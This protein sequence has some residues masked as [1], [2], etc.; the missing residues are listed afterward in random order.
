MASVTQILDHQ[1]EAANRLPERHKDKVKLPGLIR[2]LAVPASGGD[3]EVKTEEM[4][5]QLLVDRSITTAVGA[6]LDVIGRI[7]GL[8]RAEI[9]SSL[10]DADYRRYVRAKI[11]EQRS[12][13]IAFD[14][15]RVMRQI[16]IEETADVVLEYFFPAG[17]RIRIDGIAVTTDISAIAADFLRGSAAAGVRALLE[18]SGDVAAEMFTFAR[19]S[20]L[21]GAQGSGSGTVIVDDASKFDATGSIIIDEGLAT[22]ETL[23]YTSHDA[24]TFTLSGTTGFAHADNASVT[25]DGGP[26]KGYDDESAPGAGGKFASAKEGS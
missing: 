12:Y 16:F 24:T 3:S 6:Q 5:I 26:G 18:T 7:V 10:S 2:A 21:D 8:D 19:F 17:L 20:P 22:E 25:Q 23:A 13:G 9:D 11:W 15:L 1:S 14:V 4:L